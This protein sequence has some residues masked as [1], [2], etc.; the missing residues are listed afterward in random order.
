MALVLGSQRRGIDR[1]GLGYLVDRAWVDLGDAVLY[2]AH[3]GRTGTAF[4]VAQLQHLAVCSLDTT[5]SSGRIR[6]FSFGVK[7]RSHETRGTGC[8]APG[9]AHRR[10]RQDRVPRYGVIR[11]GFGGGKAWKD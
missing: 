5:I 4:F 9:G 2:P 11:R 3:G 7:M 1:K 10:G 8:R 6:T